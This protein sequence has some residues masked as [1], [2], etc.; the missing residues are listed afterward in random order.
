MPSSC[1]FQTILRKYFKNLRRCLCALTCD[2]FLAVNGRANVPASRCEEYIPSDLRDYIKINEVGLEG[3]K[4][5]APFCSRIFRLAGTLALP[6]IQSN[7]ARELKF[8]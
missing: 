2:Y 6:S 4:Y 3:N 8:A 7:P 1:R 5:K